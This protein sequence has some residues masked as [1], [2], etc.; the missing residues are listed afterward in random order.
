MSSERTRRALAW[1]AIAALAGL[2]FVPSLAWLAFGPSTFT[3]RSGVIAPI[4]TLIF[5]FALNGSRIWLA[6]ALLLP[7]ALLVPAEIMYIAR[8][9]HP[10]TEEVIATILATNSQ[11]ASQFLGAAL[12]PLVV[13]TLACLLVA[14]V[15]AVLS[16]RSGLAWRHRSR[17]WVLAGILCVP[18]LLFAI[19]MS[20]PHRSGISRIDAGLEAVGT[21]SAP[22]ERSYP[23]G[24]VSRSVAYWRQ[25]QQMVASVDAVKS[26]RFG[27]TRRSSVAQRQIYVF[28]LGESSARSHW[29]IFGY[30]RPTTP[31]LAQMNQLVRIGDMLTSWDASIAAIPLLLTRKPITGGTLAWNEAS[32]VRA[33]REA[34]YDTWWISNQLPLGLHDSPISAYALEAEHVMF[35]NASAGDL[36]ESYDEVLLAPLRDALEKSTKDTFM[37]LHTMGSHYFY[38]SRYPQRVARFRPDFTDVNSKLVNAETLINSYDNTIAYTDYVLARII[39]ALQQ[40]AAVTAL[41]YE[42]DHGETLP[43]GDCQLS[44]HGVDSRSEFEVPAFF[45][46]SDAYAAEFPDKVA[47]IVANADKRT[48][49]AN[50]FE[51]LVDMAGVEF[52]GHD[53]TWSLFSRNWKY[54]TR[55]VNPL[56]AVPVDFDNAAFDD[57]CSIPIS[58]ELKAKLQ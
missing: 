46:Y 14:V 23:L 40:T 42:S 47:S 35:L 18:A 36:G 19:G 9:F 25:W 21:L 5:V 29:Q 17:V 38:Y 45:W 27:A 16:Y 39:E 44:G 15:A 55:I 2:L 11:E 52:P 1:T 43:H 8:Y 20:L 26:F 54:H 41:W 50:T 53:E 57:K 28:V 49:S 34:G 13:A 48:L 6:C 32:I 4:A 58:P 22:L 31:E 37:V 30:E 12:M 24:V 33:M 51:S 10:S 3:L 7:F 56:T